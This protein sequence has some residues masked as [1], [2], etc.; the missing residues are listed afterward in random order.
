MSYKCEF[1]QKL[2]FVI[3]KLKI[4]GMNTTTLISYFKK[5]SYLL[6]LALFFSFQSYS[7]NTKDI[8]SGSVVIDMGVSPQT[9]DNGLKPYGLVYK[10]LR[11]YTIPIVWSM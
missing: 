2:Q 8:P 4:R 6:V 9:Y 3:K 10:L 7:Q 5:G 1:D 11:D